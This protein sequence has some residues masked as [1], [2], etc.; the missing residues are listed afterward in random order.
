[1]ERYK[2][3]NVIAPKPNDATAL[4]PLYK[5]KLNG[6]KM[7]NM[8]VIPILISIMEFILRLGKGYFL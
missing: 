5:L 3:A 6:W 4:L 2:Q 1:L 7:N 8:R